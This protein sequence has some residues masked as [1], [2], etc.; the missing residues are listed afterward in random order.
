VQVVDEEYVVTIPA[1]EHEAIFELELPPPLHEAGT[2]VNPVRDVAEQV[3]L[4]YDP[5][6]K[7]SE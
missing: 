3:L 7:P 4:K 2:A 5:M 1:L 6:T